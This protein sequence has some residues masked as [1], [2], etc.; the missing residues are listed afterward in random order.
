MICEAGTGIPISTYK[1]AERDIQVRNVPSYSE[2]AVASLVITFLLN[3]SCGM[4]QSQ[5]ELLE[6]KGIDYRG[7]I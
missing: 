4:K 7:L 2:A 3:L 6:G 5:A 1:H